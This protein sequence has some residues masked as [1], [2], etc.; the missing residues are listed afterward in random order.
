M[1]LQRLVGRIPDSA[2]GEP[3]FLRDRA[4]R[5]QLALTADGELAS[6]QLIDLA[7]PSDRARKNG[8]VHS[9]P[10]ITRSVNVAPCVGADDIQYV[11][12]WCDENSKPDRVA[13]CHIAF[14]QIIRKWAD[15]APSDTAARAIASFYASGE[16]ATVTQPERWASKQLVMISVDGQPVTELPSLRRFWAGEVERRTTSGRG[17]EGR[18]GL[19]LVCARQGALVNTLPQQIPGRLVPLAGGDQ[20]LVSGN[21][22]IHTYDFTTGLSNAPIC[23]GC[24]TRAVTSLQEVLSD[25]GSHLTY[26]DSRLGWWMLGPGSFD[27]A[28][29]L[30][31]DDPESVR[32]LVERV[33]RSGT[34]PEGPDRPSLDAGRFCAVTVS[35]TKARL[36]IRDWIDMPLAGLEANVAA[37]FADHALHSG[38]AGRGPYYP[39]WRL[40]LSAGRWIPDQDRPGGKY[41]DFTARNSARPPDTGRHLLHAALLRAPLPSSAL[42]NLVTRV[43]ADRH[44]D[45]LRAALLRLI[46]TRTPNQHREVPMA[47]LNPD[48]HD[49]AY[50]GG[51]IFAVLEEIQHSSGTDPARKNENGEPARQVNTSFT[52]RYF[53]GAV[54]NPRIAL[55]QGQQLAQAWLKKLARTRPGTASV[56]R[57][58]LTDLFDCFEASA[59]LPGQAGLDRQAAFI[60][61]YHQ[62]RADSRRRASARKAA[63]S[64]EPQAPPEGNQA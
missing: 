24:G 63:A 41:A 19:C 43:R 5:W 10:H 14:V 22:R 64:S 47:G 36:V 3:E 31:V 26:G 50:L 18:Q 54:A 46:L 49:P 62:Q 51:R 20:S 48:N 23:L 30:A 1:L 61:G 44:V 9:V 35:G 29:T 17:G 37:W 15:T 53:A 11:L 27:L 2:A 39:L 7:D 33:R 52:D 56:L 4:I 16:A 13:R 32:S 60:L 8:A 25:P 45:D 59:G 21:E 34:W 12:G 28:G 55:I 40:V 58:Q 42:A 38:T 6:A 57:Q